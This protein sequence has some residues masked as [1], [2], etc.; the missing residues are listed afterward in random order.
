M[1]TENTF[2]SASSYSIVL[3]LEY[4]DDACRCSELTSTADHFTRYAPEHIDYGVKRYQNETRRLYSVL[5]KH[6]ASDNK[7]YICGERCTIAGKHFFH[8]SSLA[9]LFVFFVHELQRY[10]EYVPSHLQLHRTFH[11][12]SD[13]RRHSAHSRMIMVTHNN[14]Y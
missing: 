1:K 10:L 5:D 11:A 7:A 9:D 8:G 4:N 12:F 2:S 13:T 6:L 14:T 3:P